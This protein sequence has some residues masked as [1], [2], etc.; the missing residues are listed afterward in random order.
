[1]CDSLRSRLFAY[2]VKLNIQLKE[3]ANEVGSFLYFIEVHITFINLPILLG[4]Y[5]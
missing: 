4:K 2:L 3:S 1:M 5:L